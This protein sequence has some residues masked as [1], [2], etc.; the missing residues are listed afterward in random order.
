ME[1]QQLQQQSENYKLQLLEVEKLN[2][3]KTTVERLIKQSAA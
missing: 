3:K 2:K 1:W